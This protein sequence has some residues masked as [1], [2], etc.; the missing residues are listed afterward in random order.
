MTS[1]RLPTRAVVPALVIAPIGIMTILSITVLLPAL[2]NPESKFYASS[3]GYPALQRLVGQPI[4]VQTATAKYD[5]VTENVAAPGESVGLQQVDVRP[6]VSGV[7]DKVYVT[8]GQ[9]VKK[10]QPLVR[11]ESSLFQDNLT[12]ARN[13]LAIASAKLRAL[14]ASSSARIKQLETDLKVNQARYK[15]SEQIRAISEE[16]TKNYLA[17][18][19]TRLESSKKKV[20]Q[21]ELLEK[22]GVISKFQL[23]DAQDNYAT[24]LRELK[25]AQQGGLSPGQTHLSSRDFTLEREDALIT[26]QQ[27]L[28]LAQKTMEGEIE[29]ARLAFETQKIRLQEATRDLQRTVVYASTDGLVSQTNIHAGELAEKASREPLLTLS[30]DIVFRAFVDQARLDAIKVRDRA[31]VRLIAQQGKTFQGKVM[32][33][34]PTVATNSSKAKVGGDRQYTYSVW[35]SVDGI[36]MPPGLQGFVQ[37]DGGK[38]SLLIPES[39][40]THLSSGEGM[41]MVASDGRATI[42]KVKLGRVVNKQREVVEGLSEGEQ[43]V[44]TP[45]ALNPGDKLSISSKQTRTAS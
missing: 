34:N 33:I 6:L 7:V 15:N 29:N 8:E 10:G 14:E 4:E 25:R 20:Q 23:Y 11:I 22:E 9:K 1:L 38:T 30:Q 26:T 21:L 27:S 45:R 16:E 35:V 18:A 43:V 24:R 37:F 32:R 42:R 2:R 12:E 19:R 31:T 3:I 41:V 36:A 13:N 28:E 44:L 40:V 17:E 39:A 5:S